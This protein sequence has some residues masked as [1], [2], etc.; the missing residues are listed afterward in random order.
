MSHDNKA[1]KEELEKWC[2]ENGLSHILRQVE[3][4]IANEKPLV[5]IRPHL[6]NSHLTNNKYA[7]ITHQEQMWELFRDIR[8]DKDRDP[9]PEKDMLI[10][11]TPRGGNNLM[12]EK[13][14]SGSMLQVQPMD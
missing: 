7:M 12:Q 11:A 4:E 2:E 10:L 14:M 1:S 3:A 9:L 13:Y 5:N 8:I 6:Y